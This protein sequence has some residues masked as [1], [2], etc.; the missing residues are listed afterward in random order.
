MDCMRIRS[1]GA[2]VLVVVAL[3]WAPALASGLSITKVS[4]YQDSTVSDPRFDAINCRMS[5]KD[6]QPTGSTTIDAGY[7]DSCVAEAATWDKVAI[8]EIVFTPGDL[9]K[10]ETIVPA[11]AI[12]AGV[13]TVWDVNKT[14]IFPVWWNASF[15]TYGRSSSSYR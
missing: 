3:G 13:R 11:W 14:N 15:K 5:W 1:A 7:F 10:N 9:S 4:S 8:L 6:F 2:L 12:S